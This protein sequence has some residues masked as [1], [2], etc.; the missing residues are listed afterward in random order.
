M[1]FFATGLIDARNTMRLKCVCCGSDALVSLGTI[2]PSIYFAGRLL[3]MP[4]EGG[5]LYRCGACGLAFRYPRLDKTEL[6]ALYSRGSV[7]NWQSAP[8]AR[9]DWQSARQW[10]SQYLPTEGNILDVGCFDGGFLRTIGPTY[11]RYGIE[12]HE[13]ASAKARKDGV[14]LIGTDFTDLPETKVVFDAVTSFDVIEHT[15]DPFAFLSSLAGATRKNGLIIISTGNSDSPSWRLLGASYWYCSIGEHLS[16]INP[17]W[18]KWAAPRLGIELKQ[19]IKFSHANETW[20]RWAGEALKNLFYAASP[21]GFSLLR[22]M[23]LGKAEYREHKEL[24]SQPP[25]WISA[26]DH[27]ICLF[28]KK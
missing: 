25:Y 26:K 4:L 28:V 27:F 8:A 19:V 1:L 9:V 7:E 5:S 21:R 16:F 6:D 2:P 12:I 15:H 13:A 18:C 3:S 24:M 22:R 20:Q 17:R 23:G 11:G 10:V 14:R